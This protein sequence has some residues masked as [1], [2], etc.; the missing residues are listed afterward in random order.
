MSRSIHPMCSFG[1]EQDLDRGSFKGFRR[2]GSFASV[3][4]SKPATQD[5]FKT[6]QPTEPGIV[7]PRRPEFWQEG[8]LVFSAE[9]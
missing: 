2:T 7:V 1:S 5:T 3:I 9:K 4:T 8:F 6:G